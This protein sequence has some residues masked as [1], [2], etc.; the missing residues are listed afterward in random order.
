MIYQKKSPKTV[1][2]IRM[3]NENYDFVCKA[4]GELSLAAYVNR[5]IEQMRGKSD[6]AFCKDQTQKA[7]IGANQYAR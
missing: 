6:T 5:L 1:L 7:N 3:T 4:A 2:P